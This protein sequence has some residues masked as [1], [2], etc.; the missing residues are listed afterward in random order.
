VG[1]R[2]PTEAMSLATWPNG[3]KV[4]VTCPHDVQFNVPLRIFYSLDVPTTLKGC[5]ECE[6]ED[7]RART[8]T[9]TKRQIR[10]ALKRIE[11]Q[12]DRW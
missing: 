7:A 11:K 3:W 6:L 4:V 10:R 2:P 5:S 8:K 12:L 1:E 9:P